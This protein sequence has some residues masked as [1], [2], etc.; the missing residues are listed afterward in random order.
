VQLYQ[1]EDPYITKKEEYV[2]TRKRNN[3]YSIGSEQKYPR[4]RQRIK[5]EMNDL[6]GTNM[7]QKK[8]N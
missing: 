1:K 7:E 6:K 8:Q 3:S 2:G 5:E 4:S